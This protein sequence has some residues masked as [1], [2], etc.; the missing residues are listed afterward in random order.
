[1][2]TEPPSPVTHTS[3]TLRGLVNPNGGNVTGC[4][5][6]YG[7]SLP[8]G[9]SV[10][11][12]PSPGSGSSPVRVSGAVGGLTANTTYEFRVIATYAGGASISTSRSF[13]TAAIVAPEFGRCVERESDTAG[14][15]VRSAR[16]EAANASTNGCQVPPT[17]GDVQWRCG[18]ARNRVQEVRDVHGAAAAVKARTAHS[19]NLPACASRSRV[20]SRRPATRSP[21]SLP[22]GGANEGEVQSSALTATLVNGQ[23][24][25][26]V[27]LDLR[28][29]AESPLLDMQCGAGSV[30]VDGSVVPVMAGKASTQSP[31]KLKASK[32]VQKPF[33]YEPAKA[34]RSKTVW[35]PRF[36]HAPV[37]PIGLTATITQTNKKRIEISTTI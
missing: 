1:M 3:A 37:E 30:V 35:K 22:S 2:I 36:R 20:A 13:T 21:A 4:I 17:G 14:S 5:V 28:P 32:G 24:Q 29:L 31:L 11:C 19:R 18:E 33:E 6:E 10:P 9:E 15:P 34:G 7:V 25:I 23:A 27:V 8:S 26:E 16:K 12:S